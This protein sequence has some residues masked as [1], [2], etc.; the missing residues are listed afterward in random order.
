MAAGAA[1]L[2]VVVLL[3]QPDLMEGFYDDHYPEVIGI[4]HH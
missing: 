4:P 3:G 1:I 2:E